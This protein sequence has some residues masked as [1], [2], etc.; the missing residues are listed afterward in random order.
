MAIVTSD[1]GSLF[2]TVSKTQTTDSNK[3]KPKATSFF[4]LMIQA[5][6][7]L[8]RGMLVT[9]SYLVNPKKI[10]TQQYPENRDTLKLPERFRGSVIMPHDQHNNHN[11]TGCRICEKACPN[12][13]I[14][15]NVT[16]NEKGK[17]VLG[18]FVYRYSQCTLCNLCIEACPFGAITMG[19]DFEWAAYDRE[20]IDQILNKR[21]GR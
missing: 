21:Q 18:E 2:A 20:S 15:I 16:T 5:P 4:K 10:V 11:C 9:G 6:F 8:L 3:R 1:L 14:S 7:S 19:T 12:A 13:T 17:K